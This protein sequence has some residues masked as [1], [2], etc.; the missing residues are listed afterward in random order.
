MDFLEKPRRL[1]EILNTSTQ[2]NFQTC[3][4]LWALLII[5]IIQPAMPRTATIL[6]PFEPEITSDIFMSDIENEEPA[7]KPY[8]DT[9]PLARRASDKKAEVLPE[10]DAPM[11]QKAPES[12]PQEQTNI[13]VEPSIDEQ[14]AFAR[15]S[16]LHVTDHEKFSAEAEA[17]T[18]E[19]PIPILPI[20]KEMQEPEEAI[21]QSFLTEGALSVAPVE[22]SFSNLE[23]TQIISQPIIIPMPPKKTPVPEQIAG[24]EQGIATNINNFN[25]AHR[26]IF[27]MLRMELGPSVVNFLQRVLNKA[28]AQHPL[29]F[30]GVKMN[31]FGELD[32][33]ALESNIQ[34][35][36]ADKYSEAFQFLMEEEKAMMHTYLDRKRAESIQGGLNRILEKHK[37]PS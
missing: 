15:E 22:T 11:V 2:S 18:N 14:I 37:L 21:Q 17:M 20:K 26:F 31:E 35:N 34:G 27:E 4:L 1:E 13:R 32:R 23:A 6:M 19:I 16:A 5:G 28:A 9:P 12:I 7:A 24:W 8:D 29:I 3:K 25:E 36:L 30:D 33:S 10:A